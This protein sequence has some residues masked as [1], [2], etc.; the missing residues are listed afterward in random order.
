MIVI[1]GHVAIDPARREPAV[2]AAREMMAETRKEQGC[3]SYTFSADL[4]EPG[5]FRI[6]EEW[7]S[8]E[9]LRAHFASPH[10]ARFR[11][12]MAGLGVREM[13]IQRYE[14]TKVGPLAP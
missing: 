11:T 7:E 3:L 8:D 2:A 4:E 6:F 13:A 14:V 1:A 10:M 12:A 9:A 5:R